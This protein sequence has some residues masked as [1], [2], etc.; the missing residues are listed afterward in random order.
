M[1]VANVVFT[2]K[3]LIGG[4]QNSLKV[5]LFD[6][7]FK[8]IVYFVHCCVTIQNK[9]NVTQ[10]HY[11]TWHADT[12]AIKFIFELWQRKGY[13]NCRTSGG[14]YN[15]LGSSTGFTVSTLNIGDGSVSTALF[16]AGQR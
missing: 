4:V 8:D 12:Q 3:R 2:D 13:G 7:F 11:R 5:W 6:G 9:R 16:N 14:G 10:T 1:A 15:V